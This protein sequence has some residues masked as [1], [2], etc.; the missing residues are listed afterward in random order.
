MATGAR[1]FPA[2]VAVADAAVPGVAVA[3]VADAAVPGVAV[4]AAVVAVAAGAAVC[5][6]LTEY[7]RPCYTTSTPEDACLDTGA[8]VCLWMAEGMT[9]LP[10]SA[11]VASLGLQAL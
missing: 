5:G 7:G 8:G 4:A 9:L 11:A 1:S 3:V 10:R 6:T 2:A